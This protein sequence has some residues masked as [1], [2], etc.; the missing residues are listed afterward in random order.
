[1]FETADLI[2]P[3]LALT[4]ETSGM[5]GADLLARVKPGA[6]LVNTARGTLVGAGALI[7]ALRDGPLGHAALD[8]YD[9][10]PLPADHPLRGLENVTLTCHA[11]FKTPEASH[12]LLKMG[13]DLL[14][15]DLDAI[16]AGRALS[17]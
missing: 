8:V 12:R 7:A 10:E 14:R 11:A 16:A 2:A 5:I 3:Q 6:M 4:D 15:A 17:G 9:E 1:M 13:S